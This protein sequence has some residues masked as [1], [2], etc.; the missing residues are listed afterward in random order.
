MFFEDRPA[1]L[2]EML[3]VLR[4]G[5]R[6]AV[7]VWASLDQLPGYASLV[8]LLRRL[9]G[10]EVA[11]ALRAPFSLGDRQALLALFAEADVPAARI[12]TL[13]GTAR[14][15]SVESWIYADIRGWTLAD[16]LDDAQFNRLLGE[17]T[18]VLKPFVTTDGTV[19]FDAPAHV[20]TATKP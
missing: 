13:T 10:E 3:R 9:F 2:R 15:P 7:A 18:V 8:D 1:A 5:G 17:A 12:T 6:L 19:A 16:V 4:S 11:N 14:F 20:V